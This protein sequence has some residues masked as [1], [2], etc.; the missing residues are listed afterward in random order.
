MEE[1]KYIELANI[2]KDLLVLRRHVEWKMALS[3]WGGLAIVAVFLLKQ[4]YSMNALGVLYYGI[5]CFFFVMMFIVFTYWHISLNG[6]NRKDL[7]LILYY[8]KMVEAK[9]DKRTDIE[10]PAGIDKIAFI[11]AW[12]RGS[13]NCFVPQALTSLLLTGAAIVLLAIN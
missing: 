10:M 2:S 1:N 6:S 8:R 5:L 7:D 12:K 4:G 3:Y 13:Y 11:Y 9:P